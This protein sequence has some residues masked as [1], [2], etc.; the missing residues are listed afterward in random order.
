ML[1][2]NDDIIIPDISDMELKKIASSDNALEKFLHLQVSLNNEGVYYES[3][4]ALCSSA[5]RKETEEL[6]L[7]DRNAKEVR[8]LLRSKGEPLPVTVIKN[9]MEFHI[10]QAYMELRK[11]EYIQKVF[12]L[13]KV[14]L[15]T[16]SRVE[17][18]LSSISERLISVNAAE[19]PGVSQAMIEKVRAETTCK[20]VA[21][22]TKLLELRAGLMG[23]MQTTGDLLSIK[24]QDFEKIFNETINEFRSPEAKQIIKTLLDK[25]VVASR[26]K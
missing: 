19:D 3:N 17:M 6:W 12:T 23:E 4:C 1:E 7:K 13:S 15:D 18:A 21:S 20:L 22:M 11:R 9:H 25:F 5:Y 8:D 2:K 26:R 14:N 24:K 16:L 10:D